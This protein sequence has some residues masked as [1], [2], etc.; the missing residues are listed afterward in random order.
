MKN[1]NTA[2]QKIIGVAERL[3]QTK[4]YNAFSYRDIANE[5]G[6]KTSSIHYHFPSKADLGAAV[7][8]QH[9][10]TLV[11]H[12][13]SLINNSHLSFQ[14]KLSDFFDLIFEATYLSERKMCLGGML[15]SDTL[16]LPE[17]IQK[18]VKIFFNKIELWITHLLKSGAEHNAFKLAQEAE[19]ES[20]VILATLEGALLLSRLFQDEKRLHNAK[21]GILKRLT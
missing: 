9:I 5:V 2:E 16:T 1:N 21:E 13:E 18:E 8:K 10:D 14:K 6:I 20:A 17:I 12:L 19:Q 15:A 3:I 4:G 7:V 11:E